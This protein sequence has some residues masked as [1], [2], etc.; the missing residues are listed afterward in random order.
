[1]QSEAEWMSQEDSE[2]WQILVDG[3][4]HN[5]SYIANFSHSAN[6]AADIEELWRYPVEQNQAL[7]VQNDPCLRNTNTDGMQARVTSR[8]HPD[9]DILESEMV[10][11]DFEEMGEQ[12]FN[13]NSQIYPNGWLFSR[14]FNK[15]LTT[16]ARMGA[17]FPREA[18]FLAALTVAATVS[19]L[20]MYFALRKEKK[21]NLTLLKCLLEKDAVNW[22]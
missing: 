21:R 3:R 2:S 22:P 16:G 9:D 17:N 11:P 13:R 18:W 5:S 7:Y 15:I 1:M 6:D 8:T 10:M 4:L 14:I 20:W 19:A 12:S